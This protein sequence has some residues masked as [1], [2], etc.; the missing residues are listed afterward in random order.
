[1]AYEKRSAEVKDY[2]IDWSAALG[3][4]DTIS[5]SAWVVETGIT[6]D[7]DSDTDTTTTIWLS[8]GT[9]GVGYTLTN[10]V[11]TAQG[12][13]LERSFLVTITAPPVT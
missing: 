13:T 5:T 10:R 11:V 7:S 9:E 2:A 3:D 1:M 8:G 6:K 12:R 4:V